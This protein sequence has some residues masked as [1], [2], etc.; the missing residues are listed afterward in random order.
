M[1]DVTFVK[2]HRQ[3]IRRQTFGSQL[4]YIRN[5]HVLYLS[6]LKKQFS[7]FSVV[8]RF[9]SENLLIL[10][11]FV[12][13]TILVDSRLASQQTLFPEQISSSVGLATFIGIAIIVAATQHFILSYIK[14]SNKEARPKAFNLD[15]AFWIVSIGQYILVVILAFV[16]L[17]III[18]QQ[19]STVTLYASHVI[20]YGFWIVILSLLARAFSKSV[21]QISYI[22]K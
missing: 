3:F 5:S 17:Q 6:H 1:N 20:S 11:G 4:S 14:Q 8:S 2:P 9:D 19:Y 7:G 16:I 18:A 12:I 21:Q 15:L 13:I 10:M 22:E